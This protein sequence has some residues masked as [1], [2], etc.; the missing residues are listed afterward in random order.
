MSPSGSITYRRIWEIL[1]SYSPGGE[2]LGAQ[3]S[4]GRGI[5][6]KSRSHFDPS[7]APLSGTLSSISASFNRFVVWVKKIWD[8]V[9]DS[10]E[11][12]KSSTSK[13]F[14]SLLARDSPLLV[15]VMMQNVHQDMGALLIPE[16]GGAN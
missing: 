13:L 10:K 6:S 12:A 5:K 4:G 7:S 8:S 16:G 14:L 1:V 3:E 11:G 9:F 15:K 2:R